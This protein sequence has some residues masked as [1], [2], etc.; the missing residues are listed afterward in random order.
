MRIDVRMLPLTALAALVAVG[1]ATADARAA[2][3]SKDLLGCQ[4]SLESQVRAYTTLLSSKI[5][6]CTEKVAKCKLAE[7]IDA[8]PSGDCITAATDACSGV[9]AKLGDNLAKRKSSIVLRCGLIPLADLEAF[10]GGLGFYDVVASC[11]ALDAADLADCVLATAS[12]A[13][14]RQVFRMEP[15]GQAALTSLGIAASFPCVAP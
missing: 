5:Y 4:K 9:P 8:V 1:I 7:E 13:T 10:V 12:C 14:Q 2:T 11:G 15:R 3:S 6:G